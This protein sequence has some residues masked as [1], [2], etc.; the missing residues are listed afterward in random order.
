M[1]Y[2]LITGASKGL[3]KSMAAEMAA[4]KYDLLLVARSGEELAK[5]ASELAASHGIQVH[6]LPIDLSHPEAPEQVYKWCTDNNYQ[7]SVLINNAG[8]AVWGYFDKLTLQQQSGMLTV[9]MNTPVALCHLFLPMLLQQPKAYILNVGSTA[10]YQA[11]RT[12]S[13]YAASKAFV[14][15]FTRGLRLELKDTG[16][17]VTCVCPGPVNTNFLER[18]GMEE[19]RATAEKFGMHPDAVAKIAIKGMFRRKA[20]IIPGAINAVSAFMTRL[21][22]KSTIETIAGGLYKKSR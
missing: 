19:L 22:P 5:V 8:Y 12:V 13:L 6:Y 10:A 4:R 2:A 3:G 15:F 20:E 16:V 14:L 18:A 1:S 17:S 11:V 21:L 9:N 7:V